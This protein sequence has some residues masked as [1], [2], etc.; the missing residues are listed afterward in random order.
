MFL[1]SFNKNVQNKLTVFFCQKVNDDGMN[2]DKTVNSWHKMII[3]R[4]FIFKN[5]DKVFH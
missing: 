4:R 1:V 3:L 5:K 2:Y